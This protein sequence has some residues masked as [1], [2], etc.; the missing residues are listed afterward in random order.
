MGKR[1][2]IV[3]PLSH[4]LNFFFLAQTK[5]LLEAKRKGEDVSTQHQQRI[6]EL[7]STIE[8]LKTEFDR[9]QQEKLDR[10]NQL[11]EQ[12]KIL[13]NQM[14]EKV[15]SVFGSIRSACFS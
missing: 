4:L 2:K 13:E 15:I 6:S 7:E 3:F 12:N 8:S 10:T 5:E 1:T 11:E 9:Q 14:K